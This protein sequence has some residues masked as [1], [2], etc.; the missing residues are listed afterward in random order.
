MTTTAAGR[1]RRRARIRQQAHAA[2][3]AP[4]S[5]MA[6]REVADDVRLRKSMVVSIVSFPWVSSPLNSDISKAPAPVAAIPHA[7][8][9]AAFG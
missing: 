6:R 2:K 3:E 1:G 9:F 8:W 5:S 7:Q 4:P